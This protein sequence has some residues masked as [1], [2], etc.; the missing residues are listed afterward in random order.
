MELF[1][2]A[3]TLAPPGKIRAVFASRN[4]ERRRLDGT[5]PPCRR[6]AGAPGRDAF[7]P[8]PL[9][10]SFNPKSES[11]K[12]ERSPISEFRSRSRRRR[13]WFAHAAGQGSPFGLRPSDFFRISG[14]RP[15]DF[16]LPSRSTDRNRQLET[17]TLNLETPLPAERA[18]LRVV[19][20][21]AVV[22]TA[23]SL[24]VADLPTGRR[25]SREGRVPPASHSPLIQSETRIPETRK[26]PDVRIPKPFTATT[27]IVRPRCRSRLAFRPSAFGFLSD[28][29]ASAFGFRAPLTLLRE[30]PATCNLKLPT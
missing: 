13:R 2:L 24:A 23:S 19:P 7:H 17:S 4:W 22:S 27:E 11:P 1:R 25:R 28:F 12:P 6:D 18:S 21:S 15:S 26:K 10:H 3:R 20:G 14:L 29:G 8:S 16:A 5:L 9:L 30:Q